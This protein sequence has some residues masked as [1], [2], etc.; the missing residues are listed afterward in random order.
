M[1][2]RSLTNACARRCLVLTFLHRTIF[3]QQ[4]ALHSL[5]A[6]TVTDT[7]ERANPFVDPAGSEAPSE[8]D[9]SALLNVDRNATLT[10]G[11]DSLIVLGI[12]IRL[13]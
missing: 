12:A 5:S 8:I 4:Y 13:K 2:H 10:L 3:R 6:M 11:T 7:N 9:P 1:T